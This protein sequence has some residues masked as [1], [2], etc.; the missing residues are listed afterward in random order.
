MEKFIVGIFGPGSN[1][2]KEEKDAA[3]ALGKQI[4]QRDVFIIVAPGNSGVMYSASEGVHCIKN[5]KTT[6]VSI[7][8]NPSQVNGYVNLPI[9][10]GPEKAR[11]DS[12][13]F[14]FFVCDDFLKCADTMKELLSAVENNKVITVVS[15]SEKHNQGNRDFLDSLWGK[16]PKWNQKPNFAMYSKEDN[17]NFELVGLS[18]IKQ[19]TLAS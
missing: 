9:I 16:Y 7:V 18:K 1:A 13:N 4:A 3:F 12:C 5:T 8:E 2:T 11:S 19:V 6:L 15:T 10:A 17:L 14:V